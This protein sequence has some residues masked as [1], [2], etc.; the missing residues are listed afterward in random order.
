[1]PSLHSIQKTYQ[2]YTPARK[3]IAT[4][5]QEEIMTSSKRGIVITERDLALFESLSTAR[6]LTVEALE[7]L[8]F[9]GWADRYQ[10]HL[11]ALKSNPQARYQPSSLLYSRL[12]RLHE[13]ELIH[14]I[15]RPVAR[16]WNSFSRAPDLFALSERG[17]L[18]LAEAT[19]QPFEQVHT[20]FSGEG[21]HRAARALDYQ[22]DVSINRC[23][24]FTARCTFRPQP[25]PRAPLPR[26]PSLPGRR[27]GS[28]LRSLRRPAPASLGRSF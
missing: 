9:P 26:G 7:W 25:C 10:R 20:L 22:D 23:P 13:A 17:A 8:H 28:A 12:R 16:A 11:E 27:A 15:C 3:A 14:R 6:Y 24:G 1:L 21:R 5:T 4:R 2:H 19:G 18:L